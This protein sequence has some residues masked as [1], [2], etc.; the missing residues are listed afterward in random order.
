MLKGKGTAQ[1]DCP[2]E[3]VQQECSADATLSAGLAGEGITALSE[4]VMG[5]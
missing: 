1:Q 5:A 3:Q 4:T 2:G